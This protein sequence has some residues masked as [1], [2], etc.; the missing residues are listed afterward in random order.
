MDAVTERIDADLEP[1]IPQFTAN[2]RKEI[3]R[4]RG[5]LAEGDLETLARLGHSAKG[6]GYGYGFTGMG[7][8]GLGIEQAAKAG[9][10]EA[11][12]A[13]VDRLEAYMDAVRVEFVELD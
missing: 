13:G 2:T 4:M 6:S 12:K 10:A 5:A 9:D 8:I 7:D 3:E 1:L 11:A